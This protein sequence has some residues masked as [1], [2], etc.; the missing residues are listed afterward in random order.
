MYGA[1][2]KDT[3]F[4]NQFKLA[5]VKGVTIVGKLRIDRSRMQ[6]M[7]AHLEQLVLQGHLRL[8]LE[9][10]A[11]TE[12]VDQSRT[13]LAQGVDDGGTRRGQGGLEHVAEHAQDAVEALVVRALV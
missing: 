5:F 2:V 8:G 3:R 11:G 6:L 9:T 1:T 10:D 7:E 12:D 4:G 13:L